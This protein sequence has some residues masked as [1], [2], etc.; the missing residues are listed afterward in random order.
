MQYRKFGRLDWQVSALGFGAMRLPTTDGNPMSDKVDEEEAI[1]MIRYAIDHGVNYV[2][3]A[4]PYHFGKSEVIVGK[5]CRTA[6]GR[7]LKLQQNRRYASLKQPMNL[8]ASLMS[9]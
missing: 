4:W 9:S 8:I 1:A 3:T 5:R 2:D 6:T 7:R